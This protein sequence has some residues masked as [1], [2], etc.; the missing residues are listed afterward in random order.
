[1]KLSPI[2]FKALAASI[3]KNENQ[4]IQ[5]C[6]LT[7]MERQYLRGLFSTQETILILINGVG[8]LLNRSLHKPNRNNDYEFY[9]RCILDLTS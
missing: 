3:Y 1:M 6:H 5:L 9:A 7:P 2:P 4:Y 8:L